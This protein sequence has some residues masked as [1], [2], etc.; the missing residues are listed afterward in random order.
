[1][2]TW[3][4]EENSS[5]CRFYESLGGDRIGRRSTVIGGKEL[6]ELCYA[7]IDVAPL[8]AMDTSTS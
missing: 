6:V 8:A 5:A 3:V 7:W 2:L 4:L 1:M